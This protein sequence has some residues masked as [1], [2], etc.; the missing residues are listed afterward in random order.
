MK[1]QKV[2]DDEKNKKSGKDEV[3]RVKNELT[4]VTPTMNRK[5][6]ID[7]NF[8]KKIVVPS[9]GASGRMLKKGFNIDNI[10]VTRDI[11][12]LDFILKSDVSKQDLGYSISL[13][14]W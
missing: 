8:N 5:G 2:K 3:K 7:L 13:V 1:L 14:E 11:L 4:R 10:D 9:F 12:N 6:R